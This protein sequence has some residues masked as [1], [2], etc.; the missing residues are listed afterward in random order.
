MPRREAHTTWT[1]T[2]QEGEGKVDLVS[3]GVAH[4][5]VS[6]PRR[7]ADEAGGSASPEELMAAAGQ[8][9]LPGLQSPHRGRHHP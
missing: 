3:S 9:G 4:F 2:L 8:G 7:A 5:D 1:G 6:L